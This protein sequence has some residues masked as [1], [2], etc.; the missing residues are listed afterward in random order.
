MNE[1]LEQRVRGTAPSHVP[2]LDHRALQDRGRR[3]RHTR[4]ARRGGLAV[5]ACVA[6]AL[7][8]APVAGQPDPRGPSLLG[9]RPDAQEAP[10]VWP[11]GEQDGIGYRLLPAARADEVAGA[12]NAEDG[13]DLLLEVQLAS[14]TS[15]H[16]W[17]CD[18]P[19][20]FEVMYQRLT[21]GAAIGEETEVMIVMVGRWSGA[22]IV[23]L[24]LSDGAQLRL[25]LHDLSALDDA[26]NLG[27]ALAGFDLGPVQGMSS[28]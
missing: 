2:P 24:D 12:G 1:V 8:A 21:V 6:V 11:H 3:R 5:V 16:A 28:D 25:P 19:G 4:R 22:D 17:L 26:P 27:F 13:C 15:D 10:P 14:G 18:P 23:Q 20:G 7:V 9:G